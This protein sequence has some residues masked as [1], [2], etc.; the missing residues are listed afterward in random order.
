MIGRL[1]AAILLACLGATG[2]WAQGASAPGT[3]VRTEN[4][5][6]ELIPA[7]AEVAPGDTVEVLLQQTIRPKWHTYWQNP[8]DSGQETAIQ[9]T[10]PPGASAG[11]IQWAAPERIEYGP[12]VNYGYSDKVGLLSEL[13]VPADWPVGKPFPVEAFVTWLVCEE[14]CI[15]EE[16]SFALQIPTGP[17]TVADSSVAALLAQARRALPQPS[18]WTARY[19]VDDARLSIVFDVP[20]LRADKLTGVYFFPTAWGV[21]DHAAPQRLA[22][23]EAG[24]RLTV[25]RGETPVDASLGGVLTMVEDTG[26]GPTRLAFA[27][28]AAPGATMP[29]AIQSSLALP[30]L[31]LPTVLL[32]AFLGGVLLNLMPCVFPVLA[33]KAL[34]VVRGAGTPA[35][36]RLIGGLA[37]LAGVLGAFALLGAV[38]LT[39]QAGGAAVGWGF[40]LQQPIVVTLFAYVL[41]AVGLNLA[42]VFEIGGGWTG[43]GQSLAGRHGPVGSFFTGVLAAVVAAPCTAPFMATALGFAFTQ[44]PVIAM[45]ALLA[46]GGGLAAPYLLLTWAPPVARLLPKPGPW[47]ATFKQAL[48]FPMFASAAWLIWVL[49]QQTGPDSVLAALLGGIALAAAAWLFA[50]SGRIARSLALVS[51]LAALWL[52]ISVRP[53][54]RPALAIASEGAESF[55]EA[56]FDALRQRGEPVLIN[57]TAAWCVTCKVNERVALSGQ[58]FYDALRQRGI[59][60]LVGD[61]TREDPDVTAM[62]RRFD[63]AGVPLYVLF[64]P[65]DRPPMVLPQLL[66]ETIVVDALNSISPAKGDPT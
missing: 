49:A 2:A 63:R 54:D 43:M 6:V 10:L 14:I 55:T 51:L 30:P 47:L 50:R 42:G 24:L 20:G 28:A 19:A 57:L 36:E 16:G 5:A 27:V 66:T 29:A 46:L 62:L 38:L 52:A 7:A 53:A 60:Y 34:G 13:T 15:P 61:W 37:Y 59:T 32:F 44:P 56:R 21:V 65:D 3:V 12:L 33:I 40:Q 9:W 58:A 48:A 23:D 11:P 64:Y 25:R 41:F 35:R 17:A 1:A 8:G 4:V 22:I 18:P 26:T 45:S 31:S 39:L